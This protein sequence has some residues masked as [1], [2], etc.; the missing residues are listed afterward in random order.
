MISCSIP[1]TFWRPIQ[2]GCSMPCR[3]RR[4]RTPRPLNGLSGAPSGTSKQSQIPT[5]PRICRWRRGKL[6][7]KNLPIKL[8]N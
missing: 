7:R 4:P 5:E 8:T 1:A 2:P 3:T 6:V